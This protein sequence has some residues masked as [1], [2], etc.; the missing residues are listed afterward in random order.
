M[1]DQYKVIV[2]P[3]AQQDIRLIINYI[4]DELKA[5]Q[6]AINLTDLIKENIK[7]LSVLHKRFKVIDEQP[8]ADEGVRK[9]IVKNYYVYY[10][11]NDDDLTVYITAVIYAGMDQGKQISKRSN[12]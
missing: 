9:A 10:A 8:W 4:A 7:G 3:E 5:P 11:V 2:T 12:N 1:S 6:A